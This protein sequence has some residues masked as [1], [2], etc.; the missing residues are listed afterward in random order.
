[1]LLN[2]QGQVQNIPAKFNSRDNQSLF[3]KLREVHEPKDKYFGTMFQL[4][5]R[6]KFTQVGSRDF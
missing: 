5:E 3:A 2:Q 1:M 4:G 6:A